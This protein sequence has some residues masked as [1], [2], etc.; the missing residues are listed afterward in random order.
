MLNVVYVLNSTYAL[1][2]ASKSFV[3]ML[4][5]LMERGVHPIVVLPDKEGLYHT[6][7][8]MG[9]ECFVSCFRPSTYPHNRSSLKDI[10]AFLPK[11]VARLIVNRLTVSHMVKA[12]KG[13]DIRLVHTNVS[14]V[15]V[16][17]RFSRRMGIPHIFHVRE[18]A[19][20]DF[21][22]IYFPCSSAFH[23]LLRNDSY[24]ICITKHIQSHH[25]LAGNPASVVIYN[26]VEV[27]RVDVSSLKKD[28]YFLFAGRIDASKGVHVLLDAYAKYVASVAAP[29]ELWIA[30][31]A[32]NATYYHKM[33]R[34]VEKY[35]LCAKVKFLGGREDIF[36]LMQHA[37]AIVIPSRFEGFGR[38]MAEAMMNGCLVIAHDTAGLKEQFDNGVEMKMREIGLRYASPEELQECLKRVDGMTEAQS[39]SMVADAYE[40]A[41]ALYA[42]DVNV[43]RICQFYNRILDVRNS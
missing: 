13:R 30:G 23:K 43:G 25:G 34:R 7:Q 15:D 1:G 19:D 42:P 21:H 24:S 37:G 14:V 10:L 16:G 31:E 28:G 41:C 5:G 39:S 12:L 4:S 9:V 32:G 3:S 17:F 6:L 11:L 35:G 38:C 29:R 2:G 36:L 26:G 33:R 20:L 8:S 18:Y 40:V 27:P 22:E